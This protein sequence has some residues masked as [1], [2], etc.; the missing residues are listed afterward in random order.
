[1][2]VQVKI[3]DE[4]FNQTNADTS[5]QILE[6]VALEGYKSKQLTTAQVRRVLGFETRL[7]VYD[8]LA[9]NAVA[10]VDYSIEDAE[11]ERSLLRELV[12]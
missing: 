3:P 4:I 11:R 9:K 2:N 12:P 1:M 7:E 10:W 5:R 6:I 8:F